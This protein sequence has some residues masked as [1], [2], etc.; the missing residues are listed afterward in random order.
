MAARIRRAETE[1]IARDSLIFHQQQ[2]AL[3]SRESSSSAGGGRRRRLQ[4]SE[5]APVHAPVV[6]S[7]AA[8]SNLPLAS[9]SCTLHSGLI[10]F[11]P[12]KIQGRQGRA[13]TATEP[14]D[15][16]SA[17]TQSTQYTCIRQIEISDATNAAAALRPPE[18]QL[19]ARA[20]ASRFTPVLQTDEAATEAQLK[21]N[22]VN[23]FCASPTTV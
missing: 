5:S 4:H 9:R 21:G 12:R 6:N 2:K 20:C 15:D 23:S 18:Q 22:F 11:S 10:T 17:L 7:V 8:R 16:L 19:S 3:P 14:P 13:S 1:C